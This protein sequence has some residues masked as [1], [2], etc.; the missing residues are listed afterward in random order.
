MTNEGE[1]LW[2]A[3]PERAAKANLSRYMA[4]LKHER[5]QSF[6]GYPSLLNWSITDIPGFWRSIWD[7]FEIIHDGEIDAI[8]T[9]DPMP[10]TRWFTGTRLNYAE[11]IL[12]HEF[13]GDPSRIMLRHCSELR[14]LGAVSW[15]EV[16]GK[17]RKLATRLRAMG[18][19]KGD[20]VVA[21]MPNIPETVI[22]KLAVTA[23]GAVWSSAAP[24]FGAQT[25]IDRFLQIKPK[26]VFATNGYRYGGKDFD[27]TPQLAQILVSLPEVEHLVMLDYLP[28]APKTVPGFAGQILYWDDMLIGAEV[29]PESFAYERVSSD[30]PLWI[31][32]SS[33]TTGLPKP[34]VH[35]HHGIVLE[36]YKS[37][38]FHFDL[39]EKDCLFFY[40]TTG[41]MMWNTLMWGPLMSAEAVLYDGHPGY[42]DLRF[43]WNLA[44][45]T[46]ATV[47]GTNPTF[48]QL[49]RQQ[50]IRPANYA[51]YSRLESVMLV[52][53]PATP[54]VFAWVYDAVKPDLWVTSQSGG[55]EFC[56]GIL[57]GAPLLPVLAGEIQARG[58]ATDA[59][60]RTETGDAV[61]DE[62]GELVIAK[63]MPSM[64]LRFWGDKDNE[65]YRASYFVINPNVW[66]HGDRVK[67]NSHGG[68]FVY[69]RSDAT[70]NRFGV[71]IGSAEIYR[72]LETFPEVVDS[73]I[74]CIEEDDGG[75]YM[76]LFV[77]LAQ[78]KAF[79]NTLIKEM[80]QR[81][82]SERSPRHVP[83]EI[84]AVPS[85]PVTLTGKK[86]EIP[87]R[88]LLL[89]DKLEN[90][91]NKDAMKN[92]SA[93]DWFAS[94]AAKRGNDMK[95]NH[96]G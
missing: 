93:L 38:A 2:S 14:P 28:S 57:A 8:V 58:L 4:W 89:G 21:Y 70:L 50:G 81:L 88:R 17:V 82:R 41:W 78:G 77:Q 32:F 46:G 19:T 95:G 59:Q 76:P 7:Y 33:G 91:A 55:T 25:V 29:T 23:I 92:P 42:P 36:H 90:V 60:A 71:R 16:A 48:L 63:P 75:Y 80:K 6:D 45:K 27:R 40:S 3:S 86:M 68:C 69:G 72:T 5:G 13:D 64:P 1:F 47:F 15:R 39:K 53:S 30:H 62:V 43:L 73:L 34:I 49:V 66:T 10:E 11:H 9:N 52:G 35:G 83:D 26:L 67:F 24:E 18:V 22:A 65:R 84:I 94:F 96:H 20:R 85:I 87:V 54:E 31:L 74:V 79:D 37:A 44:D 56:S 61:I 12:R 51:P